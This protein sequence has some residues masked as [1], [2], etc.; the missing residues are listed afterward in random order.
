MK[1]T[2]ITLV[3]VLLMFAMIIVALGLL[4]AAT[5]PK[6]DAS[7]SQAVPYKSR[8]V[9]ETPHQHGA[10]RLQVVKSQPLPGGRLRATFNTGMVARFG[11]C[12][13]EDS[14]DCYW[15]AGTAGIPGSG[16]SSFVD[17]HGQAYYL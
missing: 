10:Q 4:L 1:R 3:N 5:T 6:A 8:V 9:V 11:V 7:V 12:P 2:A 17:Y 15:D 16:G 14:R 13:E